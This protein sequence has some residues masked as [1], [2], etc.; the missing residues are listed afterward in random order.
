MPFNQ[1]GNIIYFLSPSFAAGFS[2]TLINLD[3]I[4]L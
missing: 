4:I 1:V 3:I 2:L